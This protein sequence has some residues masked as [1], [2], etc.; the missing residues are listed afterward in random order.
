[1]DQS[2]AQQ[3]VSYRATQADLGS[4]TEWI[5][6][7]IGDGDLTQAQEYF[8]GSSQRFMVDVAAVGK[9]GRGFRRTQFIV[10]T[11]GE[12]P[13]VIYRKDLARQGWALGANLREELKQYAQQQRQR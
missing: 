8:T 9:N 1:M 10:D 3:L 4:D 5:N 2:K 6:D 13:V 12:E 7:A 11:S